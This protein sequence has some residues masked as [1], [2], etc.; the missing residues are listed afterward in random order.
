MRS[1]YAAYVLGRHDYLL[2]TWCASMRPEQVGGMGLR[3]IGLDIL[4]C[5]AGGADDNQGT[6][7][8]AAAFVE[9][10]KGRRLVETSRFLREGGRWFYVDGDCWVEDVGRNVPCPCGSGRKFKQCCLK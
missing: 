5:E 2:A 4:A 7:R 9:R 3:W 6:V 1:R 10:G 8:F